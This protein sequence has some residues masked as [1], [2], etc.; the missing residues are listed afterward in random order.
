M[1]RPWKTFQTVMG[2]VLV[3]GLLAFK[4]KTSKSSLS[5]RNFT[6]VVAQALCANEE[7]AD[8]GA[9]GRTIAQKQSRTSKSAVA[10]P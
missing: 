8:D 6:N 5:L 2:K 9:A 1:E 4:F 10:S 7:E 3:N